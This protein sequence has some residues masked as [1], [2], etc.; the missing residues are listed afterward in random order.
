MS[1]NKTMVQIFRWFSDNFQFAQ[2]QLDH[3]SNYVTTYR[4]KVQSM[5]N[6]LII[7][8]QKKKHSCVYS[9]LTD[10]IFVADPTVL[11]AKSKE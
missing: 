8:L 5:Y 3:C 9:Y 6:S 4:K 2:E 7:H 1:N 11:T 10:S